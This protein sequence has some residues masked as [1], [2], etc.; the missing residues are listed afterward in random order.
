MITVPQFQN[1]KISKLA[2]VLIS[3]ENLKL[4]W[5]INSFTLDVHMRKKSYRL[6]V[7]PLQYVIAGA[8]VRLQETKVIVVLQKENS[9]IRWTNLQST[10]NTTNFDE[11]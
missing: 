3:K 2:D 1:F 6:S 5:A 8:R 9:E 11:E 4:D 10:I 7:K